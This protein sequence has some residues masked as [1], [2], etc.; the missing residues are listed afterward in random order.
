MTGILDVCVAAECLKF[1]AVDYIS[2]PF[3]IDRV[4]KSLLFHLSDY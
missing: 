4:K 1:G 2:K 3:D